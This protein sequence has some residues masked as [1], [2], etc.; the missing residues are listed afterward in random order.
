M[1]P[2]KSNERPTMATFNKKKSSDRKLK[3]NN[4]VLDSVSNEMLI[5]LK[6]FTKNSNMSKKSYMLKKTKSLPRI[7]QKQDVPED[8]TFDERKG[9][10]RTTTVDNLG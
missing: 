7:V 1:N 6:G 4:D 10:N 2:L 9:L 8:S 3:V 5:T